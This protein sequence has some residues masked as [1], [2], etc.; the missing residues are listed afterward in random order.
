MNVTP[1]EHAQ[2]LMKHR[3]TEIVYSAI[4]Q[5]N[6]LQE[7]DQQI[8]KSMET[9][10]FGQG[11]V[12]DSIGLVGFIAEVEQAVGDYLVDESDEASFSLHPGHGGIGTR[13]F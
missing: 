1:A 9:V 12:L 6:Q 11:G 3:I 10:L 4:D 13:S 2:V 8:Q 7:E 5:F